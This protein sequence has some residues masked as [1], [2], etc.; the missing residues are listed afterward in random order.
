MRSRNW[1][2]AGLMVL[3]GAGCVAILDGEHPYKQG[4]TTLTGAPCD[5]AEKCDDDNPC[6]MDTCP[7]ETRVCEYVL[8][9][10]GLAPDSEQIV[11]DCKRIVCSAGQGVIEDEPQDYSNDGI[12]CTVDA[13]VDGV[14]TNTPL[15]DG[16]SCAQGDKTGICAANVCQV[17]CTTNVDCDDANPCTEEYCNS[18][19]S[20]C[21]YTKF[22]GVPT[23]GAMQVS[24]DCKVQFCVSGVDM[25]VN[26][27]GDPKDDTNP[28][29]V[30]QCNAGMPAYVPVPERTLC[31][32]GKPDVC[33]SAGTCVECVVPEDCV[34]IVETECEKRSCV[35]N[36]CKIAYQG[37]DTLASPVLQKLG[38]CQKIVCNG[39][40]G[41]T[42][43]NDDT[44]IPKDGNPCTADQCKSG[45]PA[46]PPE[47]QNLNCGGTQVCDGMGKCVGCNTPSDCVNLPPDDFCKKRTCTNQVCGLSFTASG[48][49]LPTGQVP[50]DC[51]V[52]E[53]DGAGN[54]KTS[55]A[56]TDI[57]V[58]GKQCTADV[59]DIMGVPSNP[60]SPINTAC[61]E[62][63][64]NVC[65]GSGSCKKSTG[66]ACAV[67]ADCL[68]TY[69]VDGV[70][71]SS[72]CT[73]VCKSCA[74]AGMLGTCSNSAAGTDADNECA[75]QG[76]MTCGTTGV[77]D[78]AGA[79]QKYP[80]GTICAPSSCSGSTQTNA[81]NCNGMGTCVDRGT[82]LCS[83]Y[84]CGATAC[85]TSCAAD[86]DCVS[87]AYCLM[88]TCVAKKAQG[89]ACASGSQCSSGNCVD[90]VCCAVATCAI[91][92]SCAAGNGL[93]AALAQGQQDTNPAGT[94]DGTKACNGGSGA[95]ACLLA[96]NQPCNNATECA[97]GYCMGMPKVCVSP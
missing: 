54:V 29:T 93:C 97:G 28:C 16:S 21:V 66:N 86:S 95:G 61:N 9:A 68:T 37:T 12:A 49:D 17:S 81:D 13:C 5:T 10:E 27:D 79:C 89:V 64:N 69:C 78:G 53:C 35:N 52:L 18:A 80:S 26:D 75:D 94:C 57:P 88:T 76:A 34:N 96:D 6:T 87:G 32:V 92:Q 55:V 31:V 36:T 65:D 30:D 83:P 22:D 44:D 91:C 15:P 48:T 59:C 50:G 3:S 72:A 63:G 41:T 56:T 70:C 40:M 84:V 74:I 62:N 77:C 33:T 73:G 82:S 24:G 25:S 47:A 39:A 38:D 51:K 8:Q 71:C 46:N 20:T 85:K 90:G 7:A 11:A 4:D 19:S 23:P 58:D 1:F 60:F 67:S 14:P 43:V 45:V 42:S 2:W